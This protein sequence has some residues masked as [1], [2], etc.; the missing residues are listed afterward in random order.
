MNS[1]NLSDLTETEKVGQAIDI[2]YDCGPSTT[3]RIFWH[4]SSFSG[5][6]KIP[7]KVNFQLW[8][9]PLDAA[10]FQLQFEPKI[11]SQLSIL[12]ENRH[13]PDPLGTNPLKTPVAATF[14]NFL[15]PSTPSHANIIILAV[16][17]T[18][19]GPNLFLG[20]LHIKF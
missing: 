14:V 5:C 6:K 1:L 11:S 2:G 3:V 19:A 8:M 16:A 7:K 10:S 18:H 9:A 20:H 4:F 13:F 17:A 12:T 15:W